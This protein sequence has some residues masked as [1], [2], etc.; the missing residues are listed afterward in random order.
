MS[1]FET[2]GLIIETALLKDSSNHFRIVLVTN[3]R[4][5]NATPDLPVRVV[6]K[7]AFLN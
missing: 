3:S 2:F 4:V 7:D 5:G 1:L 6:G